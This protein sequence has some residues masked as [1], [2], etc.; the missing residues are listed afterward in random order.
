MEQPPGK[1][2]PLP[3]DRACRRTH[4]LETR[5]VLAAADPERVPRPAAFAA[6]PAF[7]PSRSGR[8]PTPGRSSDFR[9]FVGCSLLANPPSATA[10]T[11]WLEYSRPSLRGPRR[12]W[13]P[14]NRPITAAGPS[15]IHTGVP[16]LPD[17]DNCPHPAT[18]VEAESTGW[19]TAVNK[20][21]LPAKTSLRE[22]RGERKCQTLTAPR[23]KL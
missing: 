6:V 22:R 12:A 11:Q 9:A 3:A 8:L 5:Q 18:R 19:A 1:R 13:H 17:G 16:C 15:R 2:T 10:G 7:P 14:E 4:D 21:D 23:V 20:H